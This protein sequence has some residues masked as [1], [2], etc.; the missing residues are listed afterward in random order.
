M[1]RKQTIIAA[2]AALSL[3]TACDDEEEAA[4]GA[5]TEAPAAETTPEPEPEA[6]AEPAEPAPGER[7]DATMGEDHLPTQLAT[8]V[9]APTG[10]IGEVGLVKVTLLEGVSVGA[11]SGGGDVG[12]THAIEG[13]AAPV[14]AYDHNPAGDSG[15]DCPTLDAAKTSVGDA[16]IVA[17][18][19][20]AAM[21]EGEGPAYG[22]EMGLI[23]FESGDQAGFFVRKRFDHGDDYTD[24]C[25]ASGTPQAPAANMTMEQAKALAGSF[26]TA[27]EEY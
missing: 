16:E 17:E 23:L 1:N 25:V 3:V 8:V 14:A 10:E 20:F 26:M 4:E 7:V 5:E 13:T 21:W 15:E 24:F 9:T 12:S 27:R 19:R 18:H 2:L 6:E 22:D 11:R